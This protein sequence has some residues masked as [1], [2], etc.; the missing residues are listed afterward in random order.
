[1]SDVQET[2]TVGH[3]LRRRREPLPD[4]LLCFGHAINT[5]FVVENRHRPPASSEAIGER[6]MGA[7]QS[8]NAVYENF[9]VLAGVL[10]PNDRNR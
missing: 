10:Y 1:M 5:F 7:A 2:D 3:P 9:R 4:E 6:R 8:D